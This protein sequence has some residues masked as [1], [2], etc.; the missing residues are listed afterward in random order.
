MIICSNEEEE[1]SYL[2]S[3]LHVHKRPYVQ[4]GLKDFKDY[5]T[6]HFTKQRLKPSFHD[7]SSL[8][9]AV[10]FEKYAY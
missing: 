8:A 2:I 6:I 4:T 9:S 1:K 7:A 3:K 10:D 5:L